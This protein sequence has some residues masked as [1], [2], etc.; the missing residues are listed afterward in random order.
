MVKIKSL[1]EYDGANTE[2]LKKKQCNLTKQQTFTNA[3]NKQTKKYAKS[4]H[5]KV[6][7]EKV[8]NKKSQE[9]V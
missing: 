4:R 2:K 1:V 5:M 3:R 7:P 6:S 8:G 9:T